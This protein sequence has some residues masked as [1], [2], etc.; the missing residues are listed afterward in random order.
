MRG[1]K[2]TFQ[3]NINLQKAGMAILTSD[4]IDKID[5]KSKIVI[6][7][8]EGHYIFIYLLIHQKI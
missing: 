6:R 4:K 1:W 7:A 5:F 2:K 3:A 8:K